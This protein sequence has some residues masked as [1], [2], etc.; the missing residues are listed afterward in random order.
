MNFLKKFSGFCFT[1]I[2]LLFATLF[3]YSLRRVYVG[4][5]FLKISL[6]DENFVGA[7]FII[8]IS[9]IILLGFPLYISNLDQNKNVVNEFK[10]L[11]LNISHSIKLIIEII[12]SA[13]AALLILDT[14]YRTNYAAL[15]N[16]VLV[17]TVLVLF[18]KSTSFFSE[19][20]K[21]WSKN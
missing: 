20:F 15:A 5:T 19:K 2:L 21:H 1:L 4:Q 18:N 12:L 14:A 7:F 9:L 8:N 11:F 10:K 6:P 17:I 3:L 16:F 13:W